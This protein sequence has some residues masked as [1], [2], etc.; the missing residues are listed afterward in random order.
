ML[1]KAILN[2]YFAIIPLLIV[3]LSS[4]FT[5]FSIALSSLMLLLLVNDRHTVGV[6]FLM[7]GGPLGGIVRM[8]YPSLP[9]YGVLLEL[10]GLL[11][12]W[13]LILSLFRD[14][15]HSI[16][17]IAI[18]LAVF[19]LFYLIGPQDEWANDKY[20]RMCL[21]GTLMV[22]GYYTFDRSDRISAEGLGRILMVA[23]LCM[24]S[25]CI[26][27]YNM[28]PGDLQDY[29]WFR[30]QAMSWYYF[31]G[32]VHM[33]VNYQHIGMLALFAITIY[34]SQLKQEKWKTV[35][36][37][38]CAFQMVM[39]SGCRQAIFGFLIVLA[40]RAIVFRP[41]NLRKR[42]K[43]ARLLSITVGLVIS[44]Y[45]IMFIL[46]HS[47]SEVIA[48]TLS[49]GDTDRQMLYLE[50]I[51]IFKENL[52]TGAGLGGFHA[53]TGDAWPHNFFLEL[54]CET[55][56][57]GTISLLTFAI[58]TLFQ[59]KAGLLHVTESDTFFFLILS[60][61]FIRVMMSSDLPE[62]I[63]IFS[64]VVALSVVKTKVSQLYG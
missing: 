50:A 39:V 49:E 20:D 33:L 6:F 14:N 1:K 40:L 9:I 22:F 31:Q 16:L 54:L 59:R 11:L 41:A 28:N 27:F 32:N 30:D 60:A 19:G 15:I 63:E 45:I 48:K 5:S 3:G 44:Y 53:L 34:L 18:V 47:S 64:A 62:S 56:L 58:I 38:L 35:F 17:G 61:L 57:I 8:M 21:H 29:N 51:N 25:F 36:Y 10:F 26:N 43:V 55:G 13:D 2:S 42:N 7:Y 12:I 46:N 52:L 37:V 24:Y 4:G 23:T